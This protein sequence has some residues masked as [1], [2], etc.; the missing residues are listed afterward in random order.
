MSYAVLYKANETDF[1]TLGLGVLRDAI[2]PLVT[3]ERN[4]QF[5]LSMSYPV[6]GALFDE[7]KN[8]RIIKADAGQKLKAQRF[9]IIRITKPAGGIVKVY[10]EHVS[11]LSQDLALKPS[12]SYNGNATQALTTWKN[13]IVDDHPFTIFSDIQTTGSGGWA[14]DKVE[15]ARRALG[16]VAG[17][18]LDTYGGEYRFD[19]YHIGLYANRGNDSGALIAYGKN[20]TDIEQK[21][22]IANTYTSIYPYTNIR[23]EEGNESLLTLPEYFVDSEY[24]SN[25]A[26]RKIKTINFQQD[27]ITTVE[28]LRERAEQYIVDNDIGV[29]SVNLTV[30]FVDLS[31]TLDYKDL[32]LVEEI[33]LCDQVTVY[34][35]K[36]GIRQKAKVI[37]TVWNVAL[38]RYE[39]L[40]IGKARANLSQSIGTTV[41]GKLETVVTD[42]NSVRISADG[43]TK[44]FT[45]IGEPIA[46]NIND[47]WY[48]PVGDGEVEM[49][50]WN[51]VIWSLQAFSGI[52]EATKKVEGAVQ[53]A[54]GA[55]E[56]ALQAIL[57][58]KAAFN[59]A[60]DANGIA[61]T[62]RDD[63]EAIELI[64]GPKGDAGVSTYV[65]LAYANSAD[66]ATDFSIVDS[67]RLYI[68][69]YIDTLELDSTSPSK[70]K[71][72]LIKGADGAQGIQG[73][74]GVD[75][76]TPY[77][78]I[79]YATNA[80][81]TTG[82]STTDA[83]GK[84]YI[85]QY[86]DYTSAD[87]TNPA[88]Y[89]W[90]L[91]KGDTGAQGL[92]GLQGADGAQGIAGV[93][94]YTHIA[95]STSPT[96]STG[97]STSNSVGATYVGMYVDSNP[98]DSETPSAYNWTLIKGADG[99]QGIQ[100]IAGVDGRTPYLHIAYATNATGTTGFS[101]TDAVG[102][103]YIGQYTDYTSA[104]ST[105][106]ALYKWTLIKGD[107]GAQG[108][109]GLQ[110]ADGAQGIAGVSSYTHIAYSTSPTGSTGFSTSNS[111]GATYVGMYV[112]SNPTDSET[113]S[114]YNWTLIKGADGSQGI[115]GPTGAN[116]QTSYLHIAYATNST[117]TT[118]FSTTDSLA[119]TYIGQYT[120]F[121]SAD[122]TNPALYSWT[123]IKG[124]DGADGE[125]VVSITQYYYKSNSPTGLVGGSWTTAQP[126]W[127]NGTYIWSKTVVVYTDKPQYESTP[128]C[129]SGKD[130]NEN[131]TWIK[132]APT[133]D[134]NISDMVD[135]PSA[136]TKFIGMAYNKKTAT[137]SNVKSDYVWT[138]A[139]ED[140]Q[141][142]IYDLRII[143][144]SAN[145][146]ASGKN[147]V[148]RG[149]TKPSTG[150]IGDIWFQQTAGG[151]TTYVHDGTDY[152]K[153][154]LDGSAIGGVINFGNVTAQN[155]DAN[156]ITTG[157][158]QIDRGL[159]I[160][161]GANTV[162]ETVGGNVQMT[163][164]N[165]LIGGKTPDQIAIEKS[166]SQF[167]LNAE[168]AGL[169]SYDS[170]GE[171]VSIFKTSTDG[172]A[173]IAGKNIVL[174]GDT[175]IDGSLTVTDTI[176][177]DTMDIT[178]FK[179]GTFNAANINVINMDA[180]AI[181]TGSLRADIVQAG[182]DGIAQGVSMTADGLKAVTANGEYSIV[183]N[184]GVSFYASDGS[185][186]GSIESGYNAA[187]V[188]NGVSIFLQPGKFFT[189]GRKQPNGKYDRFIHVP[190]NE[191]VIELD[192]ILNMMH[193][194]IRYAGNI[195]VQSA[196]SSRGGRI[197]DVEGILALGGYNRT[198][199]GWFNG[200]GIMP[201]LQLLYQELRVFGTLNMN[202]NV[203]TNQSDIRLKKNVSDAV[204][205]PFKV[206][207][208]MR[209]INF[210]WDATNPYN[211]KKPT[212]E[213]FGMEAQYAPFLAVKDQG[214]NYLSIDMGKQ[215]N[216]NSM[217]LQRMISEIKTLKE[218]NT[219]TKKE[220]ADLK[221]LLIDRGVI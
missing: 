91:I 200:T 81:G 23:D 191:D 161:N 20:L 194:E 162:M 79:A 25:Y 53:V 93:S 138:S 170:S 7:I 135:T 67:N 137:E 184:G 106:P 62:V 126:S 211:E 66:G 179:T 147:T 196:P 44:I 8:D 185:K 69:M 171:P 11:Y 140:V 115:Q 150:R 183:E 205:D 55:K 85:G 21:E 219:E 139:L 111:V 4:G 189:V 14:I 206:I 134:T 144:N 154:A 107:T 86:T 188:S 43:K 118:G 187:D 167:F 37:K 22:E 178:K 198:D 195:W 49:Y 71:W 133:K 164:D 104:D 59:K 158:L 217:S 41:D 145:L 75:G 40:V 13:N 105:N 125:G 9:K 2:S 32:A 88:L 156:S 52:S 6:D 35:E 192:R 82:F 190:E 61:T 155:F 60:V 116:G 124:A 92:Q 151:F 39:E 72:S 38:D 64:P 193:R 1:N 214:S 136:T 210:E 99:A 74:A 220:L 84:T 76:R 31:K 186:T 100:G 50:I 221:Q 19:N 201:V 181:T 47:L 146:A 182:F 42:L 30:K 130:G 57:D 5:E 169:V 24:T 110:G 142:E 87:S 159:K 207:E 213:Q 46:T 119:K 73:I 68:G 202:G 54:D 176:F 78:H 175:V 27:D 36:L 152:I 17:S 102:K 149:G 177:A 212:G 141:S 96:G 10:A 77:L 122:S 26:R 166:N 94:S 197:F 131:Y 65:H 153:S 208:K 163:V 112:D 117:G 132:Y 58:A 70:Y 120:D 95:Y 168:N 89:K 172:T 143:A 97:F 28:Q 51:G 121:V 56:D 29:P 98:T 33:N 83:V 203:I 113:P 80:T 127:T 174:D 109:Q 101:T 180:N 114:A 204:V 63:L 34:Y 16:G 216:I 3:E 103:T 15:N 90:T 165:L 215:V 12:V 108:L 218:E 209:F 128:V 148:Y 160:K 199:L 45:G 123:L 129:I 48:K 157:N 18:I 173:Y